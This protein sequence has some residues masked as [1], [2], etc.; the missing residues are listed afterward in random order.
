M[1]DIEDFDRECKANA[2]RMAADPELQATSA[3]WIAQSAP[4]KYTYNFRWLGLPVIQFPQDLL[5]L[6]EIVWAVK[7]EVVVETGIARGGSLV[8]YAS[9]LKLLGGERRVIGIELDL[10]PH[11][12]AA[13]EAHP[14]FPGI[15]L[16]DGSS[17]DPDVVGRVAATIAGRGP[18][19]VALDSNHT[20]EHVLAELHAYAPLVTPG[21]YLVVLDTVIEQMPDGAF[22]DRPWS[23]GNNPWTAVHEFL[24]GTDRF[25]VDTD[26]EN[27]LLI[28]VAPRGYL[29]CVK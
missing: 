5:A 3:A 8:F 2:A 19:M 6:Q 28:S 9:L 29:K 24:A 26:L 22:S 15:S 12:R 10:R 1:S 16:V 25:V 18:V 7:P 11:N 4:F 23:R 20:H 17:I 21:S 13:L 14:M 27:R